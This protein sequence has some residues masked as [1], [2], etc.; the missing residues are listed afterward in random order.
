ML[1]NHTIRMP[2]NLLPV[3]AIAAGAD[4]SVA[5]QTSGRVAAW[6]LDDAGQCQV[7][8]VGVSIVQIA[9]GQRHVVARLEDGR[10][11]AWGD[12]G[13]KQ[14]DVPAGL[15]AVTAVFAGG[16]SSAA[17]DSTGKLYAWGKVPK[18][19]NEL[20]GQVKSVSIGSS[21]WALIM[22]DDAPLP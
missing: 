21:T 4:F 10:V 14:C 3:K 11:I 1:E 20:A 15:G 17:V 2:Q 5:L 19:L 8:Q 22:R 7:P 13:A 18:G 9:A 16:D 6:G 12:S